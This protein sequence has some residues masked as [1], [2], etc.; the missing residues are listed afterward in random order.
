MSIPRWDPLPRR[1]A[2]PG[3]TRPL[4]RLRCLLGLAGALTATGAAACDPNLGVEDSW[5]QAPLPEPGA[6]VDPQMA[7]VGAELFRRNCVACHSLGGGSVVGPD[8]AGVTFR[9]TP[10]W[11][12]AMIANPDSM[13]RADSTARALLAT[14][15]VP[16]LDRRLDAA[17][18]RAI[19]E[20]LWRADHGPA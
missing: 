18:V 20:F 3:P 16:M 17:R 9:R 8:L 2:R 12:R 5:A 6:L 10:Y 11:I 1:R 15:Q 13:L 4:A 19:V 14:Y 7:D